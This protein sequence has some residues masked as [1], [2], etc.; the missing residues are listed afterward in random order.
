MSVH[1]DAD[2]RELSGCQPE[3]EMVAPLEKKSTPNRPRN[4]VSPDALFCI[5]AVA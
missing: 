5:V 2:T 4:Q 1:G 3:N